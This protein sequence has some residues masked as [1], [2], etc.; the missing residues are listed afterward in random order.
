MLLLLSLSNKGPKKAG[1]GEMAPIY[2]KRALGR[3]WHEAWSLIAYRLK[4]KQEICIAFNHKREKNHDVNRKI[5]QGYYYLIC[6]LRIFW[7][8]HWVFKNKLFVGNF[9]KAA[10]TKSSSECGRMKEERWLITALPGGTTLQK[11]SETL[12]LWR[13]S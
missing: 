4:L 9:Y 11:I 12:I 5:S 13:R 1:R 8:N 6:V 10:K 7:W 2:Y 3:C